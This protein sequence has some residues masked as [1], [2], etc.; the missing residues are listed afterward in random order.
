MQGVIFDQ[1]ER[2]AV[3][4]LGDGALARIRDL[5]GHGA[6]GYRFDS[7]YPDEGFLVIIR[8]V[9]EA[10]GRTTDEVAEDFGR[11]LVPALFDIYGFL[12]DPSWNFFEFLLKTETTIHRGVKLNSRRAKPPVI[13]AVLIGPKTVNI[14][15]RSERR[16]CRVAIGIIRGA[17]SRYR[18]EISIAED[19][20]MLHGDPECLITVSGAV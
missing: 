19:L 2:F 11:G 1:L 18:T 16:L 20:C 15:Y 14:S 8:S 9:A 17:A 5:K 7:T 10:T 6:A 12:I 13:Q 3:R 4:E